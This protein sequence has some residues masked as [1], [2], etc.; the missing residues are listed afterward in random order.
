MRISASVSAR[1]GVVRHHIIQRV[2]IFIYS[3]WHNDDG[4]DARGVARLRSSLPFVRRFD[5]AKV[6]NGSALASPGRRRLEIHFGAPSRPEPDPDAS[7]APVPD[8]LEPRADAAAHPIALGLAAEEPEE[9]LVVQDEERLPSL[10]GRRVMATAR[11]LER[12]AT[13]AQLAPHIGVRA[14]A[15]GTAVHRAEPRDVAPVLCTKGFC[16]GEGAKSPSDRRG[17]SRSSQR[18]RKDGAIGTGGVFF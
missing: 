18:G 7:Q 9:R 14:E 11:G 8:P 5:R 13:R 2:G 3:R 12:E 4:T 6:R 10:G 16:R 15:L 17:G 1:R